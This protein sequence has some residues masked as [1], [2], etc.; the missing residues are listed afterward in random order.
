MCVKVGA[1]ASKT[2]ARSQ[3]LR[4]SGNRT[5]GHL[6]QRKSSQGRRKDYQ[7]RKPGALPRKQTWSGPPIRRAGTP[8]EIFRILDVVP[9]IHQLED[10]RGWTSIRTRNMAVVASATATLWHEGVGHGVVAWWRGHIPT[11]LTI[12]QLSAVRADHRVKA[13][14]NAHQSCYRSSRPAGFAVRRRPLESA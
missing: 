13:R 1:Q 6:A 7:T 9:R 2:D 3:A 8:D 10:E 5:K 14:R 11:V 12:N 4:T